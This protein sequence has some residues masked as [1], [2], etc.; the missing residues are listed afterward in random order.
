M[1]GFAGIRIWLAG[2]GDPVSFS[3][4]VG[5][6]LKTKASDAK[7]GVVTSEKGITSETGNPYGAFINDARGK[8]DGKDPA[9]IEISSLTLLLGGQSTGVTA[10]EQV[11]SGQVDVFFVMNDTN[12]S[13]TVGNIKSPTGNGPVDLT[14]TFDSDTISGVDRSKLLSGAF[15]TTLRG[16]AAAGFAPPSSAEAN[17]QLTF[18]F[19]AFE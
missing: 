4:P 11:F 10:L 19:E 3:S 7:D 6:N 9:R 5:I 12:N 13:Y 1:S 18:T 16:P 8:L 17:L 2:C 15:K 14:V